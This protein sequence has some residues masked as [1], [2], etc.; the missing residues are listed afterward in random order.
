MK[1][2]HAE[3]PFAGLQLIS[4]VGIIAVAVVLLFAISALAAA[5]PRQ[6]A[7][8][9]TWLLPH[10]PTVLFAR[11]AG[12]FG[13]ELSQLSGGSLSLEK[14]VLPD[15]V[16]P[17]SYVDTHDF[18]G[19][20]D[21]ETPGHPR[22][23][24]EYVGHLGGTYSFNIRVLDLPFL[25]DDYSTALAYLDG[26]GGA[27]LLDDL[28]AKIPKYEPLAFTMSGGFRLFVSKDKPIRTPAD[29][30]G[31]V[32]LSGAAGPVIQD[33]TRAFGAIPVQD[34]RLEF[35]PDMV[36]LQDADAAET[37]YSRLEPLLKADPNFVKY[38]TET[39]HSMSLTIVLVSKQFY[40]SLTPDQQT[41]LRKAAHDAAVAEKQ[42]N[43]AYEDTMRAEL[44]KNGTTIIR[45]TP[46]ERAAFKAAVAP[47]RAELDPQ[48]G[49]LAEE[50]QRGVAALTASS[51]AR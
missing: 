36:K 42:D 7:E 19:F 33:T 27:Q 21:A 16:F 2:P 18:T 47:V 35:N 48:F 12:I 49:G 41:A 17:P 8:Q 28:A 45:L 31:M 20:V 22:M 4:Y 23:V 43:I 50:I 39:D 30:K 38:V 34:P 1:A 5:V 15:D 44:A 9:L 46:E 24:S 29:M 32:V 13:S 10:P 3:N 6:P 51:T 40:E 26:P 25:F 11:A 37:T 14:T